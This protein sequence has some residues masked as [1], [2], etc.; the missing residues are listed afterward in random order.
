MRFIYLTPDMGIA[1][2]TDKSNAKAEPTSDRRSGDRFDARPLPPDF[3]HPRR[4]SP[5]AGTGYQKETWTE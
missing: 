5:I 4:R 1:N 2:I 3:E